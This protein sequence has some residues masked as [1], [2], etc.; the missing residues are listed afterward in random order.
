[1]LQQST[2]AAVSQQNAMARSQPGGGGAAMRNA[3]FNAGGLQQ[4]ANAQ[5]AQL[6]AQESQA[7]RAQQLQ[8][9]GAV[10]Q[11]AGM[12]AGMA[13]QL[14][15]A[16]QGFAQAQAGQANYNAQQQNAYNQFQQGQEF[17]LGANN[18]NAALT[19][20][21]QNDQMGLAYQGMGMQYDQMRNQVASQNTNANMQYEA[22]KAQAAGLGSANYN[23]AADRGLQETGMMLGAM[24]G[25][26]GAYGQ[27]S[28]PAS[29]GAP[30]SD[31]RAKKNIRPAEVARALGGGRRG[32]GMTPADAWAAYDRRAAAS[33][34][35]NSI[36]DRTDEFGPRTDVARSTDEFAPAQPLLNPARPRP[37]LESR[38]EWARAL[39]GQAPAPESYAYSD[40]GSARAEGALLPVVD[41][42][43]R[44]FGSKPPNDEE[45]AVTAADLRKAHGDEA[46]DEFLQFAKSSFGPSD[47]L[48]EADLR[49]AQPYEYEYKDPARHG[50][51]TYVGPMAQDL[52]HIPGV[53]DQAPDGTKRINTP[54]LTLAQTGAISEQQR[55]LDRL[56]RMAALGG[57]PQAMGYGGPY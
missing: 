16:D 43:L 46:A 15:G 29:S 36:D 49:G 7:H 52:E 28:A 9:L 39:G 23:A 25:A 1:M 50:E 8:A 55:R 22:A 26:A 21:Q 45:I 12:Q 56:E 34:A 44:A 40:P 5:A 54:R 51:G 31:I 10:Q 27:M 20:R 42:T 53:V 47:E 32:G 41:R 18:L 38:R 17:Q 4:Q 11:G 2:D 6:R 3:A 24:S 13:G 33:T 57:R 19:N 48:A 14:R 35:H 37:P 30:A